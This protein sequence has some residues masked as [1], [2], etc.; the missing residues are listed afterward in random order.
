MKPCRAGAS[1]CCGG[2]CGG[3]EGEHFH[4]RRDWEQGADD[5]LP[6]RGLAEFDLERRWESKQG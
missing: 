5:L 6:G 1:G 2:R 4:E 3:G